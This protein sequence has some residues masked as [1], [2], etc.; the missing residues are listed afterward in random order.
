MLPLSPETLLLGILL[1]LVALRTFYY[2]ILCDN[3]VKALV[4]FP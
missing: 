3:V 1:P 4:A 2:I